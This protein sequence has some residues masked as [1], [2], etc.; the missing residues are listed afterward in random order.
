MHLNV[1][2]IIYTS[3]SPALII[4]TLQMA[5]NKK[6]QTDWVQTKDFYAMFSKKEEAEFLLNLR[7][8]K[9]MNQKNE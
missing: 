4:L 2:D 7:S 3:T 6:G 9:R 8:D 5:W 1:A